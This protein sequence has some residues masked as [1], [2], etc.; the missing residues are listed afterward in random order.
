M[1]E[2]DAGPPAL[3]P[4]AADRTAGTVGVALAL[5][6]QGVQI[7]RVHDVLPV[8]QALLLFEASGGL[9]QSG[10]MTPGGLRHPARQN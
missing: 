4:E 9:P 7:L 6:A 3:P 10:E 5:A 2:H 1:S 8:R